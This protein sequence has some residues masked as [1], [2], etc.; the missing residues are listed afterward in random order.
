MKGRSLDE[1]YKSFTFIRNK[2]GP[3][4]DFCGTHTIGLSVL[5]NETPC[6]W[7]DK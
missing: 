2:S 3:R 7:F 6:F 4:I 1:K 5:L